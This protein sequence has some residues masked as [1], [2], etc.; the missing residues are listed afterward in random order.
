MQNP[1]N[2][3]SLEDDRQLYYAMLTQWSYTDKN[4]S[5][6]CNLLKYSSKKDLISG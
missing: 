6:F 2:V 5:F 4:E 3:L 1:K